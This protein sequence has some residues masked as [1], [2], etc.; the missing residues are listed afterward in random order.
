MDEVFFLHRVH[1]LDNGGA[2]RVANS[3]RTAVSSSLTI[4]CTR[5]RE[6]RI[7]R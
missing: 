2:A 1:V 4:A 6:R 5:A 3:S 7:S